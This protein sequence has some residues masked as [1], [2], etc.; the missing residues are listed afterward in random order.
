MDKKLLQLNKILSPSLLHLFPFRTHI[1]YPQELPSRD[2]LRYH[3]F[4]YPPLL[5]RHRMVTALCLL[6]H[7]LCQDPRR[8]DVLVTAAPREEKAVG[9]G[10]G[11]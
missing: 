2:P 9:E 10:E 5:T 1:L 11:G 7:T 3:P 6:T 4:V 8:D